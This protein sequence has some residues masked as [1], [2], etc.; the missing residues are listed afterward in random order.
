MTPTL[1]AGYL[2]V[3]VFATAEPVALRADNI[4]QVGSMGDNRGPSAEHG[5][6]LRVDG[7]SL[8]TVENFAELLGLIAASKTRRRK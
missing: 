6:V 8:E 4:S 2:L 7:G 1:P 5:Y 3:R